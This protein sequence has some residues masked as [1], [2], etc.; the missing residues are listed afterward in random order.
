MKVLALGDPHGKLPKNLDF[1]VRRNKIELIICVGDI[2]FIPKKPWLEESWK[3]VRGKF[4]D[5]KYRDYVNKIASFNLP[6]LTLRGDTYIRGGKKIADKFL[7]KH[8]NVINKWTGKYKVNGQNFIFFD[9]SFEPETMKESNRTKFFVD[10]MRRNKNRESKLN[11]LLKENPDSILIAHNPPY[12]YADRT[13][14]GKHVGSK[15]LLKAIKKYQPKLVLCGHIH[16]AKGKAK[17]EKIIIYNL[18]SH[19]DYVIIDIDKNK[20]LKSNFLI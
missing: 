20:I 19:G 10:K 6:F 11:K 8:K 12:G 14:N 5:N 9:V 15:I 17:I 1:L 13:Y 7:R 16:E 4:M 2:G 3:N 18:G